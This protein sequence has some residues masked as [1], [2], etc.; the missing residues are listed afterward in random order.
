MPI[1]F[2]FFMFWYP[3]I[4]QKRYKTFQKKTIVFYKILL[5]ISFACHF[6]FENSV[7]FNYDTD[8]IVRKTAYVLELVANGFRFG[9]FESSM[10][11]NGAGLV[12]KIAHNFKVLLTVD[13]AEN[14]TTC[15]EFCQIIF[16]CDLLSAW[17]IAEYFAAP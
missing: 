6:W 14:L 15:M 16:T 1:F 8:N 13:R 10:D 2:L 17:I 7:V 9:S 11:D 4:I 3:K 5:T 12:F